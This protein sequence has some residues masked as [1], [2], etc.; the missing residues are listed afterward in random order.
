M[1]VLKW[2]IKLGITILEPLGLWSKPLKNQ[3]Y[4][5]L[6]FSDSFILNNHLT[7]IK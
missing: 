7:P 5:D 3:R 6:Y 4:D 2:R 1:L